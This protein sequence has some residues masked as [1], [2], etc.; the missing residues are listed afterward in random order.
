[1][2]DNGGHGGSSTGEVTVPLFVYYTNKMCGGSIKYV[3]F[4]CYFYIFNL[5][6]SNI[7]I[8]F[9]MTR[10][11]IMQTDLVPSISV[12]MG[13][14]IP[15][16]NTGKLIYQFLQIFS[17]NKILFAYYYNTQQMYNNYI[18]KKGLL[19]EGIF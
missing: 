11:E 6:S 15:L 4:I 13:L 2:R 9:L 19:N 5:L 14:P 18:L 10:N 17:I 1:M 7:F 3:L 16:G 12:I 8:M